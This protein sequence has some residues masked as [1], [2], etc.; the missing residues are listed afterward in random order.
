MT[1]TSADNLSMT[2]DTTPSSDEDA[3]LRV[4][5]EG[6][7]TV[8]GFAGQPVPDE[9]CIA[10]YRDQLLELVDRVGCQVLAVDCSGLQMVPSGL[11]GVLTT[12][13]KK[14]ERIEIH[15]ACPDIVDVLELTKL[16]RLLDIRSDG[17]A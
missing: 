10:A 1:D 14:V 15:N 9:V 4:Y 7:L 8:I 3:V 2:D 6:P 17:A 5:Q 16:N 11:L 13:R 12:L